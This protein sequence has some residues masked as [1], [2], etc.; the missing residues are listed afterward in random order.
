[1]PIRCF[2]SAVAVALVLF[3]AAAL[4]TLPAVAQIRATLKGHSLALASIDYSP[5]GRY[6]ATGSYDKTAK[7]WDA[8]TGS[9]IA[10]LRGHEGTVEAVRFSPDGKILATG[11]YDGTVKLWDWAS[12]RELATFRGHTNM[13]RSLAYAP[14][15][16]T[17]ASGSHDNTIK[18]WNVATGEE[19]ATLRH[20]GAV[21]SLNRSGSRISNRRNDLVICGRPL[22][23]ERDVL[24]REQR[25]RLLGHEHAPVGPALE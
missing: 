3:A 24:Q 25:E 14:D 7:I 1:M 21:I 6:L 23:G 20:Q 2:R 12:G 8:V 15:G 19:R 11:S 13:I 5:D 17:V 9:E 18:L 4:A 22:H 10:T 16:K